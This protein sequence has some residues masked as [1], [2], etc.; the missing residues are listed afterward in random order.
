M[1]TIHQ[2]LTSPSSQLFDKN[3]LMK[4]TTEYRFENHK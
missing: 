1:I 3:K 2:P 4:N